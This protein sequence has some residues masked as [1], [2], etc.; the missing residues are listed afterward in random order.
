MFG[1]QLHAII[2]RVFFYGVGLVSSALFLLLN[3]SCGCIIR[4]L[5]LHMFE[6][7]SYHSPHDA[8]SYHASSI[9][10]CFCAV[11]VVNRSCGVFFGVVFVSS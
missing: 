8:S 1:V 4:C 3:V 7:A 10:L 2:L 5:R 9:G 11:C 6:F